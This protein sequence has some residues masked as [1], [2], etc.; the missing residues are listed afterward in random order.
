MVGEVSLDLESRTHFADT[1]VSEV[2]LGVPEGSEKDTREREREREDK[3][4]KQ[5]NMRSWRES[6]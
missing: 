1:D 4:K 2:P 3:Q 6:A 5:E